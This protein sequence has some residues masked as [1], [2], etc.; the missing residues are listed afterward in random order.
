MNKCLIINL[1]NYKIKMI[2]LRL[3]NFS[4]IIVIKSISSLLIYFLILV[5]LRVFHK[6]IFK[7]HHNFWDTLNYDFIKIYTRMSLNLLILLIS[8]HDDW[9]NII[10]TCFKKFQQFKN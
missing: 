9:S 7:Y 8:I 4:F 10:I 5:Y 1:I 2:V 3:N 6:R